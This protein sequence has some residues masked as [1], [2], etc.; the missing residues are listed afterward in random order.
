MRLLRQQPDEERRA[1]A[2]RGSTSRVYANQ[3]MV[4]VAS[5]DV[6]LLP[7]TGSRGRLVR[8]LCR[9]DSDDL[10]LTSVSRSEGEGRAG[11][12]AKKTNMEQV[13]SPRMSS[14]AAS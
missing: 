10:I 9:L 14:P 8:S 6:L 2:R 3:V 1:A 11:R 4:L 13:V 5:L 12:K 7:T